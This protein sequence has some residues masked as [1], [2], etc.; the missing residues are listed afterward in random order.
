MRELVEHV[1]RA[2]EPAAA[3]RA[4]TPLREELLTFERLQ[5]ALALD[6]G[7][8]FGDIARA[9]G[10]SRQAAHRRYRDLVGVS[11][12]DPRSEEQAPRGRML[13]TSEARAAVNLARE[14]A[15]AL[16]ARAVGS[17]HLLL[18]IVR[19]GRAHAADVLRDH[20]VA[21]EEARRAAQPT[22]VDGA[23]PPPPPP[24][25]AAGPHGISPYARAVFE[26]SLREAVKRGDGFIGVE[27]LLLASLE[28]RDGGA[29][30]TL[31]SLGVDP[32]AVR[33]DLS[34][35]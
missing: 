35:G 5:V 19:C 34:A 17:E 10:I 7:A 13:V 21:L 12:Q 28:D 11:L 31:Y 29:A 2:R 18:G 9:V 32:D 6:D 1:V 27:H 15:T 25:V 20:G 8:S 30:R 23:P 4:L 3:L 22:L 26:Q 33:A 14:E 24:P 16:G